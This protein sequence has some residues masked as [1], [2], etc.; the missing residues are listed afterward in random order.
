M[1]V[2]AMESP[3]W[4]ELFVSCSLPLGLIRMLFPPERQGHS[5]H[6]GSLPVVDRGRRQGCR[7][8]P[9]PA[10]V[11]GE[12]PRGRQALGVRRHRPR[13]RQRRAGREGRRRH[14]H[15]G[16]G[17]PRPR[18][19]VRD[20][21]P[22]RPR[23]R[24]A[25][26]SLRPRHPAEPHRRRL[27][28]TPP[29]RSGR[30]PSAHGWRAPSPQQPSLSTPGDPWTR[31]A[32]SPGASHSSPDSA[33]PA[34]PCPNEYAHSLIWP[35]PRCKRPTRGSHRPSTT[36]P[37]SSPPTSASPTSPARCATSH[38]AAY[39]HACPLLGMSAIRGLEPVVNLARL[40]IRAGHAD[41]GRQRLLN[42]YKAVEA[43]DS[44]PVRGRQRTCGPHCDRRRPAGGSRVAVARPPRRRHAHPHHR[45][46]DGAE[47][48]AHIEAH[49][50]IGKADAR[51]S[52][53]RRTRRPRCG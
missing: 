37:R 40:Q 13:P 26:R 22:R 46:A 49:H 20:P 21:A 24:A 45:R 10:P 43:G 19:H 53:S 23:D 47:A 34:C 51:R 36:R 17:V 15:L 30:R 1:T 32:H 9:R 29:R 39:L 18:G 27:A 48:L 50:G 5:A 52:A 31:T 14:P 28:M 41:E 42:L 11:E 38:A 2:R 33:P 7:H 44:R 6:R 16:P 3:E 8:L 25:P 4:M 12:D 35:T